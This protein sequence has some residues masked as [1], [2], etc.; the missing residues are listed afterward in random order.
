MPGKP[1]RNHAV[2][3]D[4]FARPSCRLI[5]IA[6]FLRKG[7]TAGACLSYRAPRNVSGF[8]RS[9]RA[10]FFAPAS[11]IPPRCL[12][13]DDRAADYLSV[14][15]APHSAPVFCI[16]ELKAYKATNNVD[17]DGALEQLTNTAA[18]LSIRYPEIS[19][20]V[21]EIIVPERNRRLSRDYY[22][23]EAPLDE[24]R[25][26]YALLDRENRPVL[27]QEIPV[28]VRMIAPLP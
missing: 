20:A 8:R 24:E 22:R 27:I 15:Q 28:T 21:V 10:K 2:N 11:P 19:I 9:Q 26:T 13:T 23:S 12:K 5:G 1:I 14:R 7:Y 6:I 18:D 3:R 16:R 17:V 25:R 4:A